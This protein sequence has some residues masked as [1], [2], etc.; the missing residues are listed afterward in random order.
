[1]N[2]ITQLQLNWTYPI[3]FTLVLALLLM[4]CGQSTAEPGLTS[5]DENET[6]IEPEEDEIVSESSSAT[7]T[8]DSSSGTNEI[9]EDVSDDDDIN[10]VLLPKFMGISVFDQA[11]EGAIEAAR[12]LRQPAPSFVGPTAENSVEGQIKI[13]EDAITNGYDAVM[14]SN[15]AG[16]EIAP[17][18]Q[19]AMDA[20]VSVV[21]WDSPIPSAGGES[22]FVA[23]V[24]FDE[25][26]YVM[27]EMAH[28]I[29]NGNGKFAIL[30]ATRNSANQNAW[31]AS[32]EETI[33]TDSK[34]EGLELIDIV[35]GDD[36]ADKSYTEALALVEA[37]PDL[38][39]IMSPT[40]VGIG[41]A[42]KAM[43]D[44]GMCDAV[45]T[46]GLGL[47]AEMIIYMKDDCVPQFALWSFSDLGYLTY[48]LTY[49]LAKG[50]I[51]AVEGATFNAGRMG[52]FTI[53]KDP[54]R[55]EGLRVLMG[56]FA[57][58]KAEDL[59]WR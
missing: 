26:G 15:N 51:E 34:Y 41:A 5:T 22:V 14:I 8:E 16:D 10:I 20:G 4:G 27:A 17:V 40:T 25:T 33:S 3:F 49:H 28:D 45:K 50:N 58:Y 1:M 12:N 42:A 43:Q 7:A 24:D 54:T 30:S 11:N 53:E 13:L 44:E 6:S 55:N 32:M 46:S 37:Y 29:L 48:H 59:L 52:N 2:K 47:P 21:T 56:S 36:Q 23:Q 18:A 39:L 38:D 31:I 35:Y 9:T 19:R 57:I